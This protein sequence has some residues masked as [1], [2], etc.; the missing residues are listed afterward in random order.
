M[1][2]VQKFSMKND[3]YFYTDNQNIEF[4][5][6][7]TFVCIDQLKKYTFLICRFYQKVYSKVSSISIYANYIA[8]YFLNK[9]LYLLFIEFL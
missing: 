6:R 5:D 4:L 9:N 3:T 8:A 2:A 7:K 1:K